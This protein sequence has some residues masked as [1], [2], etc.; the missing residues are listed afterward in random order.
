MW[1]YVRQVKDKIYSN[2]CNSTL[3]DVKKGQCNKS[4][5]LLVEAKKL[6]KSSGRNSYYF[7]VQSENLKS[8]VCKPA[9]AEN[10]DFKKKYNYHRLNS[11]C[12]SFLNA[13]HWSSALICGWYASQLLCL[14]RRNQ[15]YSFD[16]NRWYYSKYLLNTTR[17]IHTNVRHLLNSSS[18]L[19]DIITPPLPELPNVAA[20]SFNSEPAKKPTNAQAWEFYNELHNFYNENFSSIPR[21]FASDGHFGR[22]FESTVFK[23]NND[24]ETVDECAVVTE[25]RT[26][27]VV[28]NVQ[29]KD[30]TDDCAETDQQQI[31]DAQVEKACDNLLNAIGE[32]EFQLGVNSLLGR[33]YWTAV[34]HFKLG[35]THEHAGATFNLGLCYEQGLGVKRDLSMAMKLYEKAAMMGH[36]KA[37][38][39][40][41]VFYVHGMGGLEKNH[42]MARKYFKQAAELGQ[43]DAMKALGINTSMHKDDEQSFNMKSSF[44]KSLSNDRAITVKQQIAIT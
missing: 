1:R 22:S 37:M 11:K 29:G 18:H 39:N 27:D 20:P 15:R 32:I 43:G 36:A 38:Y 2:N 12:H 24:H 10:D 34:S 7:V 21:S 44:K 30:E 9:T 25:D 6:F 23:I 28:A 19:E 41:G 3:F 26:A 16:S 17:A 40:L 4:D 13:L 35:T 33:N 5:L 31:D 42:R 8:K 14:H